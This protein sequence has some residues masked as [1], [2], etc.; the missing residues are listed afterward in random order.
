MVPVGVKRVLCRLFAC[1]SALLSLY[2]PVASPV[3]AR[4][5]AQA[6]H[7]SRAV[8]GGRVAAVS[9][10][11]FNPVANYAPPPILAS[12]AALLDVTANRWLLLANADTSRPMASTTKIMTA[13][14]AITHE[15][16]DDLVTIDGNEAALGQQTG[17]AM[18]LSAGERVPLR[19]LLYGLLLPSG[20]DAAVAIARS[21]AGSVPAFVALMNGAARALG[22]AHTHYANPHGLPDDNHYSSPRDLVLLARAAM[23]LPLFHQIVDRSGFYIPATATHGAYTLT[24]VNWFVRW[25]PGADGVKPG[26]TD[27]AGLCQVI[28]AHRDGR[29]LIG[30]LMNTPDLHTDARDL[31]NY[32]LRDFRWTP[33]GQPGDAPW[34]TVAEGTAASPSLYVPTTGHR[35]R[36]GFFTYFERHGGAAALGYPRTDEFVEGGVTVQYFDRARLWWDDAAQAAMATPLGQAAVPDPTLLRPAA[37][38]PAST[39]SLYIAATGHNIRGGFLTLFQQLG[40]GTVGLPVT[41]ALRA[42]NGVVQ[43]FSNAVMQWSPGH[44]V[45]LAPLGDLLLHRQG[46]L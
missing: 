26:Y 31:M 3:P 34:A 38:L 21:V 16:L 5:A 36:A 7:V 27:A 14:L 6:I 42:G 12:G 44:P 33:S 28:S 15:R 4:G 23:A 20:N 2:L 24:N 40:V 35:V 13:Y 39:G 30:A 37:A 29:W 18:G 19:D 17:A 45:T 46:Y 1:G 10:V 43:Y 32:G 25:Y 9:S 8:Q 41:E 11:P 22:L